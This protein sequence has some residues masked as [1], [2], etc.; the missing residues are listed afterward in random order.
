LALSRIDPETNAIPERQEAFDS[1]EPWPLDTIQTVTV[2]AVESDRLHSYENQKKL[3]LKEPRTGNGSDEPSALLA[4]T[5]WS[6]EIVQS[7]TSSVPKFSIPPP[8]APP[9]LLKIAEAGTITF[10]SP[11]A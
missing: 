1:G 9:R 6:L 5:A 2:R 8:S 11:T 4:P 7:V 3:P 10:G